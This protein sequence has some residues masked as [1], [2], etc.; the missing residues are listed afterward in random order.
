M[1]LATLVCLDLFSVQWKVISPELQRFPGLPR[2]RAE[3][4]SKVRAWWAESK[5]SVVLKY[6]GT[7]GK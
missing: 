3:L 4:L 6:S 2:V 1:A 7:E 5:A